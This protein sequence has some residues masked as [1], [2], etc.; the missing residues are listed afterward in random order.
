M[1]HEF[2]VNTGGDFQATGSI[3]QRLLAANM[4]P[5]VLRPWLDRKT[6]K[7]WKTVYNA[8]KEKFETVPATNAT[9]TYDQWKAIDTAVLAA[10]RTRLR[11]IADLES[12]GL[13]Y[14]LDGM[15]STVL[16]YDDVDE[17]SAAQRSMDPISRGDKDRP[18]FTT[19]YLPLPIVFKDFSLNVRVLNISQKMGTPLDTRMAEMASRKVAELLE[20]DLF[21]GTSSYAYGGGTIYGYRDFTNRNE[22]T[23]NAHWND[24]AATGATILDDVISL[25]QASINDS[26]YGPW[27]LYIP[28]NFETAIEADF[29]A[30]SDKSIRQRL[31]EVDGLEDIRVSDTLTADNVIMVQMTSDVV[32]LVNGMNISVVQWDINGGLGIEFKVM[33]IKV[34]Q[35]R[36]D[37]SGKC[38]VIHGSK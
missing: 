23:L 26:Y 28:T 19:K 36:A 21:N 3:G 33:A 29:K 35:I 5:N 6:G 15:A 31:L 8:R 1:T 37:Q 25:K 12:R 20:A 10:A 18:D 14:N 34:P 38:G 24:S 17:M 13:T 9:L 27:V 11:G 22:V 4:D 2:M 16:Q 30:A 7:S 32:R